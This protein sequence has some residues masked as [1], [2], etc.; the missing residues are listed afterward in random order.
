MATQAE[1][2]RSAVQSVRA[3]L[4]I[5][6]RVDSLTER[7]IRFL[8]SQARRKTLISVDSVLQGG[9]LLADLISLIGVSNKGFADLVKTLQLLNL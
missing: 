4:R 7:T 9:R 8:E 5:V 6:R 2:R 3:L 1:R